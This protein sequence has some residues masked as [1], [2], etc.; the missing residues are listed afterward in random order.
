MGVRVFATV[1]QQKKTATFL[2]RLFSL[3]EVSNIS[4][5]VYY[6]S[7]VRMQE[8]YK[9]TAGKDKI[10]NVLA[11]PQPKYFIDPDA[12]E[13]YLGEIYLAQSYIKK[14]AKEMNIKLDIW[15]SRLLIH[16]VLHLLG[17]DHIKKGDATRMEKKETKIFKTMGIQL[18]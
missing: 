7:D 4:V 8:L 2:A 16:G 9:R 13:S 5:D 10:T 3:L 1:S 14:E 6:V 11:F 17:F 18:P 12:G 15:E